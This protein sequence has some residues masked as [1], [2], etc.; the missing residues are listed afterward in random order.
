MS[1]PSEYLGPL[2]I[3]RKKMIATV[4]KPEFWSYNLSLAHSGLLL[5]L[6]SKMDKDGIA[7]IDITADEAA[8]LNLNTDR[9]V[10]GAR[11]LESLGFVAIY[12]VNG[13][14]YAWTPIVSRTQPTKGNLKRERNSTLPPP[15]A[16][17]VIGLVKSLYNIE[18][19]K[20]AKRICPR[21]WGIKRNPST[22]PTEEIRSVF[23]EWQK[24]QSRPGGCLFNRPAQDS[25]K[26]P[27]KAGFTSLQLRSL[28]EFAYEA[29][30]PAARFW[31]GDNDRNRKYLGIENL[32][33]IRMMN[34]RISMLDE[35][36]EV[37]H[38]KHDPN[39]PISLY[40]KERPLEAKGGPPSTLTSAE[41]A[42]LNTQ[43]TKILTLLVENGDEGVWTQDLARTALKYSARIS[44]LRGLGYSI[45]V[46]ERT[47]HG[48]N[49][50]VLR[51][52]NTVDASTKKLRL[53]EGGK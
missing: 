35:Y 19:I 22:I 28:I 16:E 38:H 14:T 21:A 49:R 34:D 36:I 27:L 4:I 15:S 43:Q 29:D 26:S 8:K 20:E 53:V 25:I 23:E 13:K 44:E 41:T 5:Y 42:A 2:I 1:G 30:H 40:H 47:D 32:F 18:S 46:A 31:R 11:Q 45:V 39:G 10:R 50:Y 37:N 48:N 9:F 7:C 3:R 24:R 17:K 12:S 33:R 51:S 52:R 6:M